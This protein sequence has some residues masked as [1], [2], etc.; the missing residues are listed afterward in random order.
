VIS[1]AVYITSMLLGI[2]LMLPGIGSQGTLIASLINTQ[3]TIEGNH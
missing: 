2:G 3:N 1:I